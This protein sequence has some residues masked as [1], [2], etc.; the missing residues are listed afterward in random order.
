M[1]NKSKLMKISML[2]AVVVAGPAYYL[3][4]KDMLPWNTKNKSLA[5]INVKNGDALLTLNDK[6]AITTDDFEEYVEKIVSVNPQMKN[7]I[8]AM[9]DIKDRILD[10]LIAEKVMNTWAQAENIRE[11]EDFKKTYALALEDVEKQLVARAF[12][13]HLLTQITI[14][15][16]DIAAHFE[17]NKDTNPR[18][19][20]DRGGIRAY[21]V[22]FNG[23]K[24]AADWLAKVGKADNFKTVAHKDALKTE[25]FG[26]VNDTNFKVDKNLKKTIASSKK[27]PALITARAEDGK[28]WVLYV[29]KKETPKYRALAEVS[30]EIKTTLVNERMQEVFGKEINRLKVAF[31]AKEDRS[32][33]KKNTQLAQADN[34][35]LV[36]ERESTLPTARMV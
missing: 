30:G 2:V 5:A 17:A 11:T 27:V 4:H 28:E 26:V 8:Q 19:M 22:A 32:F 18:F 36:D 6:V 12:Q 9:P 33:F 7:F 25:D 1:K 34:E 16:A 21:G 20:E 31:G 10:G 35:L 23:K 24:Q 13:Q 3:L 15:D 14:A 29:E